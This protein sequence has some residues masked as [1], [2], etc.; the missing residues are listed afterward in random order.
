MALDTSNFSSDP[1]GGDAYK[2]YRRA[3][4]AA[5][6]DINAV[7]APA[8]KLNFMMP[9]SGMGEA[10]VATVGACVGKDEQQN[11]IWTNDKAGNLAPDTIELY[12]WLIAQTPAVA[13][14]AETKVEPETK[15]AEDALAAAGGPEAV[16]EAALAQKQPE[17]KPETEIKYVA[18]G[19]NCLGWINNLGPTNPRYKETCDACS[20]LVPCG[21]RAEAA[22]GP[23]AGKKTAAEKEV[24]KAA[25]AQAKA[26]AK[27]QRAADKT[28]DKAAGPSK[29]KY[30]RARA[31]V[32]AL[33]Q[34][35]PATMEQVAAKAQELYLAAG[36]TGSAEAGMT[37]LRAYAV[38]VLEAA[39]VVAVE[40]G[41]LSWHGSQG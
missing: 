24:E 31:C 30:N 5:I 33:R 37:W 13:Q 6:K 41:V 36:N 3:C 16:A 15:P 39:G 38:E 18:E 17:T 29:A 2:N 21:E 40:G 4:Q 26:D 14:P 25:K 32:D 1:A 28:A 35:C 27:A 7:L 22:K 34:S 10:I 11:P 12:T 23:K 20:K 19:E 9:T 8:P